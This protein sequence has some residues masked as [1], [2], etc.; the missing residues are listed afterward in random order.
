MA[1]ISNTITDA[2]AP[3][4]MYAQLEPAL[5][6]AGYMLE[7]TVVISTRTHK[8]WKN[9]AL[10]NPFGQDWYIDVAYTTTGIGTFGI[11]VMEG[12][13]AAT[14]LAYRMATG[15]G[16][17]ASS[18]LSA[19][20]NYSPYGTTG[21]ALEATQ[22]LVRAGAASDNSTSH[23]DVSLPAS[24]FGYWISVTSERVAAIFSVSPS[25]L[26]YSGLYEASEEH[27]Y[28]AGPSL[29]PLISATIN[30]AEAPSYAMLAMTR[31]PKIIGTVNSSI[32]SS[33]VSQ[34]LTIFNS[35]TVPSG[36]TSASRKFALRIPLYS[37][38]TARGFW[39]YLIDTAAVWTDAIVARGD[40][41]TDN[42]SAVWILSARANN[43]SVMFKRV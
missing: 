38:G 41:L 22:W 25:M 4:V 30:G 14:N 2:N 23:R 9:P 37:N 39:G 34:L 24:S 12:Y 7:D 21:Y 19:A 6:S 18:T 27:T 31:Y 5:S 16:Y 20:N 15:W 10:N 26:Y 8:I 42:T 29:F 32:C 33:N 40:T 3:S 17:Y 1:Y 35:P 11:Y 28:I 13:D 36:D 43:A